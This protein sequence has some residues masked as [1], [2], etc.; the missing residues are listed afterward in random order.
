M[1]IPENNDIISSRINPKYCHNIQVQG[2][3]STIDA[4]LKSFMHYTQ[5]LL[6]DTQRYLDASQYCPISTVL[7]QSE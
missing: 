1:V 6:I 2:F 4:I 7:N 3:F 5:H